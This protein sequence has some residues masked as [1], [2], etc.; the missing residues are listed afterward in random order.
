MAATFVVEDGTGLATANALCSVEFADQY[1]DDYGDPTTGVAPVAWS[2]AATALKQNGIRR[3]TQFICTEFGSDWRG[4]K[5]LQAQALCHPRE[6]MRDN[7]GRLW[8]DDEVVVPV[9]QACALLALAAIQEDLRPDIAAGAGG[10]LTSQSS[11][12]GA[13]RTSKEWIPG[14][15]RESKAYRTVCLLLEPVLQPGDRLVIG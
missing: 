7:D 2:G 3:A 6:G 14:S 12:L 8:S 1:H 11:G 4:C 15:V 9:Q 13:L 5:K 10:L